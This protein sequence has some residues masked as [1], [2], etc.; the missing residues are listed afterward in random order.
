MANVSE[1]IRGIEVIKEA[2]AAGEGK[3]QGG[4]DKDSEGGGDKGGEGGKASV[5][6]DGKVESGGEGDGDLP[7]LVDV[8]GIKA[9]DQ[10]LEEMRAF[11]AKRDHDTETACETTKFPEDNGTVDPAELVKA[12]VDSKGNSRQ[13]KGRTELQALKA[14]W[15]V[16][17][18]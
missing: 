8:C 5:E 9:P 7:D 17:V 6:V 18:W 13:Q 10:V 16:L 11:A 14:Q 12:K 15:S 3:A 4:G 2:Q 1:A